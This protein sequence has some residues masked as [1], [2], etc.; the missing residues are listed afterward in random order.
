MV[1]LLLATVGIL[2][3]SVAIAAITIVIGVVSLASLL[4]A[5]SAAT[6]LLKVAPDCLVLTSVPS[7]VAAVLVIV[8]AVIRLL[9]PIAVV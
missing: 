2:I 9:L 5:N 4:L 7:T 8:T 6:V 3:A 1:L